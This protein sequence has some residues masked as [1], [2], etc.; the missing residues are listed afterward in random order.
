MKRREFI[1]AAGAVIGSGAFGPALAHPMD[2]AAVLST[3]D[4]PEGTNLNYDSS[5][6]DYQQPEERLPREVDLE[7][8]LEP[9][10]IH[11]YPHDFSLLWTLPGKRAI[12]YSVGIGR[13]G[14]YH[15]GE[16]YVGA[17]REWPSWTPTPA[18]IARNPS[19]YERYADGM[20][21]GPYNPLGSRALYLFDDT[22]R[23]TYLRIHGT[24]DPSTIARRVS[25]GCARLTNDLIIGLYNRVP[26]DTRVVL[27]PA[28]A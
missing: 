9:G 28:D 27:H 26:L 19:A 21:G 24:N 10:E 2:Y 16:F 4:S 5:I 15:D 1:Y 22:G 3:S 7:E 23:D 11:V 17:K 20:P 14:L 13:P 18:M 12:R 8:Y 6:P 25:N